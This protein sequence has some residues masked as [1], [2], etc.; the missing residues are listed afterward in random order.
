MRH[1]W[2]TWKEFRP[3]AKVMETVDFLMKHV[4]CC[5]ED[6]VL[7]VYLK[8]VA[9]IRHLRFKMM[10]ANLNISLLEMT[11]EDAKKLLLLKILVEKHNKKLFFSQAARQKYLG[12]LRKIEASTKS[13]RERK[14]QTERISS[15]LGR[16]VAGRVS[17]VIRR[18][19][20]ENTRKSLDGQQSQSLKRLL[21]DQSS[22]LSP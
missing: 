2:D 3:S 11:E 7:L 6:L 9:Q 1:L 8:E 13:T 20:E 15:I 22:Q 21:L 14:Q 19:L 5:E 18:I 16:I 12:M 10:N 4:E 17:E